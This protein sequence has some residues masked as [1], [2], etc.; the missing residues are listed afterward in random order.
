MS[1]LNKRITE[2]ELKTIIEEIKN[3]YKI[4]NLKINIKEIN[5]GDNAFTNFNKKHNQYDLTFG[6]YS[7]SNQTL[8]HLET[9]F[10]LGHELGHI[11]FSNGNLNC[12]ESLLVTVANIPNNVTIKSLLNEIMC[13]IISANKLQINEEIIEK[14]FGKMKICF[15]KKT[16][17]IFRIN[18]KL[19]DESGINGYFSCD[20]R[21]RLINKF[22][23]DEKINK[24][25]FVK[26]FL[27]SF[28]K[29]KYC[30]GLLNKILKFIGRNKLRYYIERN[31]DT[32]YQEY[33]E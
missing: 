15:N 11:V 19:K 20:E 8:S 18:K 32:Y 13:D 7:S 24:E 30:N 26:E 22:K 5:G 29:S 4:K 1:E 21:V 16:K 2:N 14:F 28:S 12:W 31:I 9:K 23:D 25:E 27:C 17:I 10:F 33:F 6:D 3:E